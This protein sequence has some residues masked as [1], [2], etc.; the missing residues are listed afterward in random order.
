MLASSYT[1]TMMMKTHCTLLHTEDASQWCSYVKKLFT[2]DARQNLKIDSINVEEL[3]Y[4]NPPQLSMAV[5]TSYL[6]VLLASPDMKTYMLN[7]SSW[8]QSIVNNVPEGTSLAVLLCYVSAEEFRSSIKESYSVLADKKCDV[9]G[10]DPRAN[11]NIVADYID[12]I[13][14]NEHQ[15]RKPTPKQRKKHVPASGGPI[16]KE[17]TPTKVI[18]VGKNC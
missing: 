2:K 14:K 12:I 16:V 13:D 11:T 8:F 17:I 6:V 5:K 18:R 7:K 3:D 10:S 15:S 4:E 1:K 9:I